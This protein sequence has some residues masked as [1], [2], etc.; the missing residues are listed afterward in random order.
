MFVLLVLVGLQVIREAL[1]KLIFGQSN[2]KFVAVTY[3]AFH[4]GLIDEA[5]GLAFC[6]EGGIGLSSYSCSRMQRV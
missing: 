6:I 3:G 1:L 5:R 2:V 4:F